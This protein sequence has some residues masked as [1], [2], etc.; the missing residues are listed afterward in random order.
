MLVAAFTAVIFGACGT[1]PTQPGPQ[2]PPIQPPPAN[3]A[4]VI[5]SVT[6]TL[7]PRAE[8]DTDIAITAAVT[9]AESA[10]TALTFEWT[11][12]AGTVTGSGASAVWRLA[13]GAAMTPVEARVTVVVRE[14]Y[15]A[16]DNGVIVRREHRVEMTSAPFRVHD[17]RAEI[18]ALATT[19]LQRFADNRVTPA[20]CVEDFL[21]SCGGRDA[22]LEDIEGVRRGRDIR[23][24]TIGTPVVS[25]APGANTADAE[26][27]CRFESIVIE[28]I[29]ANDP[30][31]PGDR[32]EADAR[33]HLTARFE[34][35]RWWLC[36][37]SADGDEIKIGAATRNRR[38]GLRSIGAL[39]MGGKGR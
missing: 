8:V 20:M 37:S 17:S 7:P 34:Q 36:D 24:A 23:A 11:T 26:V 18:A 33:C 14:G 19:F 21:A 15:D 29:D 28:K 32:V 4:P 16:L 12:T 13:T 22:E 38:T 39:L 35:N 25:L 9:D 10:V 2:P 3:A 30:F 6:A 27:P 1:P 5:Q 31:L